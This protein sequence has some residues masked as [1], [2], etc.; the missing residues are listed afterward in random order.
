MV[1]PRSAPWYPTEV[2]LQDGAPGLGSQARANMPEHFI[3]RQRAVE[4][5]PQDRPWD[6]AA[7]GRCALADGILLAPISRRLL[8]FGVRWLASPLHNHHAIKEFFLEI[9]VPMGSN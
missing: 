3:H 7:E 1:F 6:Q 5:L 2:T 9:C 8:K 4:R